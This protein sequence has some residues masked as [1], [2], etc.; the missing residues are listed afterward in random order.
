LENSNSVNWKNSSAVSTNDRLGWQGFA[1]G[2]SMPVSSNAFW[3]L[4]CGAILGSTL[5]LGACA[6]LPP[7]SMAEWRAAQTRV[8]AGR[9]PLEVADAIGRVFE[10]SR[11]GEYDARPSTFGIEVQRK[12]NYYFVLAITQGTERWNIVLRQIGT[13]TE[14]FAELGGVQTATAAGGFPSVGELRPWNTSVY[15][16]FWAR[17]D[18]FLGARKDWLGCAT[19]IGSSE[20]AKQSANDPYGLCGYGWSEGG[21]P[22]PTR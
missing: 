20:A 9:A 4:L 15:D 17:V 7:P 1:E 16:V 6:T 5:S 12:W 19:H 22:P 13:G 18:F 3:R 2:G 14:A 10:S 8:F 21:A 11:P